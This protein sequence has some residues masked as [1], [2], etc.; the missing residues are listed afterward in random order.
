[1]AAMIRGRTR[2][3]P[4]AIDRAV[5]TPEQLKAHGD[6]PEHEGGDAGKSAANEAEESAESAAS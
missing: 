5:M 3:L 1:M 6:P 4:I 2:E